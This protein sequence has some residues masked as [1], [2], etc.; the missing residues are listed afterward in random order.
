MVDTIRGNRA[1]HE[2]DI[3]GK[4]ARAREDLGFYIGADLLAGIVVSKVGEFTLADIGER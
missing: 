1:G 2:Q 3:L 4:L